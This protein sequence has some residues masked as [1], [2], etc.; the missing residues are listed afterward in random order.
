M[1]SPLS[2]PRARESLGALGRLLYDTDVCTLWERDT[3]T[4]ARRHREQRQRY[5]DFATEH[6]RSRALAAD[7]Q[8]SDDEIRALFHLA[9]AQGLQTEQLPKPWGS[10][11]LRAFGQG[12]LWPGCSRP[13]R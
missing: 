9:A 2:P 6:L 3:A 10:A 12:I 11:R 5:R 1:S 4:L 7:R 8:V 13:R